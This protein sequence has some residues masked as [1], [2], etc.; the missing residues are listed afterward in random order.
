M[1]AAARAQKSV[2]PVTYPITGAETFK[3]RPEWYH[4][5]YE[6]TTNLQ[7]GAGIMAETGD[8]A[9]RNPILASDDPVDP[10]EAKEG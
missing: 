8:I 4:P 2:S 6:T 10:T 9:H 5:S 3:S 7:T 1:V